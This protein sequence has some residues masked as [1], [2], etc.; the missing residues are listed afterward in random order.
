MLQFIGWTSNQGEKS[1]NTHIS[2]H[3]EDMKG[4]SFLLLWTGIPEWL[5]TIKLSF[6]LWE[7][8]PGSQS[9][10][11][12]HEW[13]IPWSSW[14]CTLLQRFVSFTLLIWCLG[15][16]PICCLSIYTHHQK[17]LNR[18]INSSQC[19]PQR[20][21]FIMPLF[22]YHFICSVQSILLAIGSH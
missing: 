9:G 20:Q 13:T 2:W 5:R 11:V 14:H 7:L 4:C 12:S 8:M 3:F 22:E 6:S 18:T 17:L 16:C 10:Q 15:K 19:V 1:F 21:I